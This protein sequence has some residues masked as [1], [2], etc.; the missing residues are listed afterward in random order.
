MP[1]VMIQSIHVIP[2]IYRYYLRKWRVVCKGTAMKFVAL[3]RGINVGGK[4]RVEMPRLKLCIEAL[5]CTDVSTY[6]N[7][8]NVLF[9]DERDADTLV[10]LIEEV[11]EKEFGFRV[12]VVIRD[13]KNIAMLCKE[14][15]AEWVNDPKSQRTDVM[16]LWKQHDSPDVLQTIPFKPDR[17]RVMYLDGAIVWN[18]DRKDVTRSSVSKLIAHEIYKFMTIRNINTVRKLHALMSQN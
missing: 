2:D 16:F 10:K 8:G 5:G 18:V 17:E 1:D 7:S 9:S 4:C 6:I 11:I 14:I 12:P 3:L 15:P 13:Q